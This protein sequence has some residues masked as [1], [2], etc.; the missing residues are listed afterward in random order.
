MDKPWI[1]ATDFD[2]TLT[3]MDVGNEIAEEVLGDRFHEIMKQ[4]R[5][6]ALS[7]KDMQKAMWEKFPMGEKKF[8]ERAMHYGTLKPGV[9]NFLERCADEGV[10]VYIASCGLRP[11]IEATL[12]AKLTPKAKRAILE[13]K[14]NEV[15]F[16]SSQINQ[17]IPP[18][19]T[20][21]CPFPL[22]KGLWASELKSRYNTGVK[23]VG[24]GNGTSDRSFV[25]HVDH[26]AATEAL[27]KWFT[28]HNISYTPFET[29]DEL[30]NLPIF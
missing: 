24:I 19:T 5:S 4:Y 1:V 3:V 16:G 20:P 21:E 2:G 13:I 29:F 10:P 9:V 25:G 28:Q 26:L 17:F 12:E 22:D 15:V 14:C 23:V 6:G 30:Q 8:R 27:A 11:Y 18:H 7:L